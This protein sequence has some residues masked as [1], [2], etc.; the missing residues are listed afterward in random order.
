MRGKCAKHFVNRNREAEPVLRV[1]VWPGCLHPFVGGGEVIVTHG[2]YFRG[3][4]GTGA[5]VGIRPSLPGPACFPD[6][7]HLC[8]CVLE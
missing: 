6:E 3:V 4:V 5:G 1:F 8:T 2:T 7:R